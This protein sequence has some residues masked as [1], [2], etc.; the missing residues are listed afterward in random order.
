MTDQDT[1]CVIGLGYVGLPVLTAFAQHMPVVGFD[2]NERRIE[3]LRNGLDVNQSVESGQV[4]DGAI[5][6]TSNV[7]DIAACSIYIVAV[8]TPITRY[9]TPE[10][11]PLSQAS[12]FVGS[13]L[14]KGDVVIF[15]STVYPGCTEELCLPIIEKVS[16]LQVNTDFVIGYS[17]E[18]INPGD[19]KHRLDN[20][21]KIV[22]ASSPAGLERITE[23]YEMIISAG[24]HQAPSMKVAEAAKIV[25]N[26][27]RDLNIALMNELSLIFDKLAINTYDVL[28]AAGTKWNFHH[29]KPGLVGGHC[30]SV[31]PYYL[32]YKA[33]E[34]GYVPDV[35]LSGRKVN[36]GIVKNVSNKVV[37]M[38]TA[39]D[40]KLSE[41]RVL[42]L[43]IT[44]KENVS[45]LRN[46]KVFDLV[47]FLQSYAI[48]VHV[49]DPHVE[50]ADKDRLNNIHW[51]DKISKEYHC[52]ILA[53]PHAT[54]IS[55]GSEAMEQALH[56]G[57]GFI[58]IKGIFRESHRFDRYWTL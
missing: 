16:G 6:Y 38:I 8:P 42:I 41:A 27:Q 22:S 26:V 28:D 46:S 40:I 36:D 17:P 11:G 50:A 14:K 19:E 20:T 21:V 1:L 13:V 39:Q 52:I 4:S 7:E 56:P 35:I 2:I 23:L 51:I 24:V 43:G 58:D 57:G 31:D 55:Q 47:R 5:S 15:E 18:R 9:K 3:Q 29:Y 54:F 53:V 33:E 48:D 32:T 34:V 37:E 25:E 12:E 44:F 49:Q 10:L 30:I 45:D